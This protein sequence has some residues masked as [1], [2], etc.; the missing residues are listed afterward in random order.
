[1]GSNLLAY[2]TWNRLV[3]WKILSL[4]IS[5]NKELVPIG[6]GSNQQIFMKYAKPGSV[7]WIFSIPSVKIPGDKNIHRYRPTLIARI[8]V[9]QL[10]HKKSPQLNRYPTQGVKRLM[11]YWKNVAISDF[12]ESEFYE[13]ND[14]T[15]LLLAL[16]FQS[17][18]GESHLVNPIGYIPKR[19]ETSENQKLR[20]SLAQ[21]LQSVRRISDTTNTCIV[22]L[23]KHAQEVREN[24]VFISYAHG[25]GRNYPL[26]LAD[27]LL[28][29]K[30][31][32]W[33]DS[34]AVPSKR[35]R[36]SENIL[37]DRLLRLLEYGIKGSSLFIGLIS[38][39]YIRKDKE[40]DVRWTLKEWYLAQEYK[41][42]SSGLSCIQVSKN[43]ANLPDSDK[44]FKY[45]QANLL[46]NSIT[47]WWKR[48]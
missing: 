39:N 34:I 32:P 22:E 9:K 41:Q 5:G 31:S 29:R 7:I 43:T 11:S 47:K 2:M 24:T 26:E 20:I 45:N 3:A 15:K 38:D 17:Q 44:I 21:Q 36:Q 48:K 1:M 25:D 37:P 30:W 33:V 18:S 28:D 40:I 10:L 27:S 13:L 14:A 46:A 35:K 19:T 42:K 8:K 12:E 4:E 6:F 16:K 23:E